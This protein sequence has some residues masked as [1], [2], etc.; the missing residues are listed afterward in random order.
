[1]DTENLPPRRSTRLRSGTTASSTSTNN[2]TSYEGL[3]AQNVSPLRIS[4]S[5]SRSKTLVSM[6]E[7]TTLR[8]ISPGS[9]RRNS[10][11]TF[12]IK[13][14]VAALHT[15]V[16]KSPPASPQVGMAKSDSA[17]SVRSFWETAAANGGTPEGGHKRQQ[18]KSEGEVKSTIRSSIVK[19]NIFL[20][21]DLREREGSPK[22]TMSPSQHRLSAQLGEVQPSQQ[23]Q[24]QQQQPTSS[25]ANT[26]TSRI[27]APVEPSQSPR[28]EIR[29]QNTSTSE[30][31]PKASCLHSTRIKGPRENVGED[32]DSPSPFG[33]RRDRRKTVTFDQAPQVLEFD[34]RSSH[35]TTASDRSSAVYDESAE[36]RQHNESNSDTD[37]YEE[38]T[39]RPLP[40]IPP[41]PLPQVP[42]HDSEDERPSSKESN[43]SE[44][45]NMEER[46]RR[47]MERVELRDQEK[48]SDDAEQDDIFS[49][50]TTTNEMEDDEPSSQGESL[51]DSQGTGSTGMTSQ[52]ESQDDEL[53]RQF[54][55]Q[56]QAD[57]LLKAVKTRPFSA[58][59]QLPDLGFGDDDDDEGFGSRLGLKEFCS[60]DPEPQIKQD[61]PTSPAP[62]V[63]TQVNN[64]FIAPKPTPI[65]KDIPSPSSQEKESL[66]PPVTPPLGSSELTDPETPQHQILPPPETLPSTPPTSPHKPL[67]SEDEVPSPVIPEREAT[68]RS[69][70]TKL[71]VRPSLSRQEAESIVARR[72]KSELPPL[73]TLNGIREQSL[74]LDVKVKVEEDDLSEF[75]GRLTKMEVGPLLKIDSLGFENDAETSGFGELAVEEMERV[76]EAQKVPLLWIVIDCSVGI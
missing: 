57:D 41:R 16:T 10:P 29:P 72:R 23:Q 60:P 70:G 3:K 14:K 54:V 64:L 13:E 58:L 59:G 31:T 20:A 2:P 76:I 69:R 63:N 35:G 18:S 15:A 9:S 5:N 47:M 49:L 24:Q 45:E 75:G 11:S 26:S 39:S 68:I 38:S 8:D 51:F 65:E 34:R 50:Y 6:A 56:K 30:V 1:M 61:P 19:N 27:P 74:D 53:E 12:Q 22:L 67:L 40:S 7:D 32:S 17:G 21:N 28:K 46:I 48:K 62:S 44:Y 55:L 42:P 43:E 73:P 4:K 52:L 36:T 25:T 37:S 71:R 33:S 66:T